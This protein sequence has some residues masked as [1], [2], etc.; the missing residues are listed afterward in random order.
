MIPRREPSGY[1]SAHVG[2]VVRTRDAHLLVNAWYSGGADVV[3]F[4]DPRNPHEIAWYDIAA[5]GGSPGSVNWAA[6]WYEGPRAGP[7]TWPI[8]GNDLE[9]NPPSTFGFEV[10]LAGLDVR[11]LPL[12]YLNPQTQERVLR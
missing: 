2:N 10:F 4:T 11:R 1:C 3:D 12:G 7:G 9:A 6:Y 5:A 8:Y